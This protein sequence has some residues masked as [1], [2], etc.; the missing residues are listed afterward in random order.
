V[1]KKLT[2][3][4]VLCICFFN[5]FSQ[6]NQVIQ[7]RF[8]PI[9]GNKP[10]VIED[11]IYVLDNSHTIRFETLKFYISNL[12]LLNNGKLV[13]KEAKIFHL[14]DIADSLNKIVQLKTL[15]NLNFNQIR[16]NLGIDS[17]TNVSGAMGGDLDPTKGMY[18][19]W[20]SGY[21][22]FKLEGSSTL[23]L[24]PKKEFQYHLGGYQAPFNTLQIVSLNVNS[25][26]KIE[27]EFDVQQFINNIDLSKQDHIMSPNKEAVF[28]SQSLVKCFSIK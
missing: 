23:C 8:K 11:S 5:G 13:W 14:Y 12:Q 1:F 16:F 27:V 2:G 3:I 24:N 6:K 25:T 4:V 7:L 17:L 28:L 19:T 20:Q 15:K 10:L 22:N 26:E 9:Y 21:V 18:W